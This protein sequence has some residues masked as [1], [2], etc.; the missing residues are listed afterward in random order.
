MAS[1]E[2]YI[3]NIV[4]KWLKVREDDFLGEY[5]YKGI[6]RDEFVWRLSPE[7]SR[8]TYFGIISKKYQPWIKD[9]NLLIARIHAGNLL[10]V[11]LGKK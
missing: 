5:Y 8:M 2:T 7:V 10:Y 6:N 3:Q 9:L 1:K 4:N 11:T